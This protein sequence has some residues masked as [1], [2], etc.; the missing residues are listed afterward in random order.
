VS[1]RD[2][3][4][5]ICGS[6]L[7]YLQSAERLRCARC[8]AEAWANA[9]CSAGHFVCDECH[10]GDIDERLKRLCLEATTT[11]PIA[12]L[13]TAFALRQV[14]MH[15][16][17]HHRI[18]PCALLAAYR[19]AGGE[20]DLAQA[21]D[22]ALKR[23]RS[24][25][26]GSCGYWGACGA[27]IGAGIFASLATGT[28]PLSEGTWGLISSLV[29]QCL[30]ENAKI[31]GPRCCKRTS[32]TAVR[33]SAE[34]AREHLGVDMGMPQRILCAHSHR[35]GECKGRACPYFGP[36]FKAVAEPRSPRGVIIGLRG[37]GRAGPHRPESPSS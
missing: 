12:I 29:A 26:G 20:L 36:A 19:N 4:C 23:G 16:P 32:F 21:L 13:E 27:A 3:N 11:D 22:E 37:A 33:L 18:V 35:N 1:D 28:T 25:P 5:L 30:A 9:L 24:V 2:T 10:A 17:E 31:G 6:P 14:H 34:F 15:G 8:G 7:R